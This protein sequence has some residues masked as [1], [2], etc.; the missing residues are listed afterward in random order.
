MRSPFRLRAPSTPLR[1]SLFLAAMTGLAAACSGNNHSDDDDDDGGDSGS[2]GEAS[3]GKG[4]TS[5]GSATGGTSG[6]AA[7]GGSSG[8][9]GGGSFLADCSDVCDLASACP[10]SNPAACADACTELN[11]LV[12]SNVCKAE[13]EA[14]Y[15]CGGSTSDICGETACDAEANSLA[16]CLI[17]YCTNNT[18]AAF[19]QSSN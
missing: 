16:N 4:G 5:G 14:L 15:D 6:T 9:G 8:S 18:S 11:T 19:C 7:K 1:L 2:S 17:E 13:I 3:S 10:D 12:S